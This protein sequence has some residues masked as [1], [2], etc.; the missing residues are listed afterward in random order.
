M[1]QWHCFRCNVKMEE[2]DILM[3]YMDGLE[4]PGGLGL[5]CPSCG[6]EYLTEDFVMDQVVMGEKMLEGK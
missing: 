1:E 6:V 4:M 2:A 5:R 3:V